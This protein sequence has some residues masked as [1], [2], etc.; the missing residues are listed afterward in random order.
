MERDL[1]IQLD[2]DN[3]I[4]WYASQPIT[5]RYEVSPGEARRYTPD[6]LIRFKTQADV[7]PSPLLC[8]VKYRSELAKNWRELKQKF[9]AAQAYCEGQ[10]WR[11]AVLDEDDIRTPRLKN[12][13]LLWRYRTSEY[14][15]QY[16]SQILPAL[17]QKGA[18]V[19]GELID[20]LSEASKWST[21]QRA[22]AIWSWWVLV[23]Q[24]SITFNDSEQLT[25][26]TVFYP[27]GRA[28]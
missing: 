13:Q 4:D 19:Q 16:A 22:Q 12:I 14:P 10:G 27:A 5:I 24:G 21:H 25:R 1:L 7:A 18:S 11:F 28:S 8:E 23:A 3:E 6:V 2:W 17:T 20:A 9:R 26:A 15:T